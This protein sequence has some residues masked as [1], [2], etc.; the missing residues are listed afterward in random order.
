MLNKLML[1]GN[2]P[3]PH[4]LI[5]AGVHGDEYEP[6]EAARRVY[7]EV[8]LL[9][10]KLKGKLTIVP[11]VNQ[12]AFEL[13][14]RM[15]HDQLDLARVCPG[16]KS[17]IETE[18][19]AHAVSELIQK[20]DYYIDMHGGGRLHNIYP[21]AGYML[22]PKE[23]ILQ[24]QRQLAKSF[25]LPIV[26]GT[27]PGLQGRTL[28]VARDANIPAIYTEIGGAG[29][30]D[31]TMTILAFDGCMNVLKHLEM[32]PGNPKITKIRYH[33]E[34]HRSS[35]GHLQ[36]M[37]PSPCDGFYL[38]TVTFGQHVEVGDIIGYVQDDLGENSTAITAD[39]SGI[40]FILR[41]PPAVKKGDALGAILPAIEDDIMHTIY[42]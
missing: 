13:C 30:Y 27:E 11:V 16:D 37:L 21:F 35:S 26:W 36:K 12:A 31:E 24:S 8:K 25:M 41:S 3:G 22:H 4:L 19:I 34:D 42:E 10:H 9:Q 39:Q 6:M 20:A 29:I 5:T 14:S 33:V 32:I 15:G 18:R 17:G 1:K 2:R 7:K 28:S 40:V 38:P 23:N